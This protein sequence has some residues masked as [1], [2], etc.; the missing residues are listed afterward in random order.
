MGAGPWLSSF[1]LP[2]SLYRWREQRGRQG[3]ELAK[4][5]RLCFPGFAGRLVPG[6]ASGGPMSL[7]A[8]WLVLDA[9]RPARQAVFRGV[10]E[11]ASPCG[12]A[13]LAFLLLLPS[14]G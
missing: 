1:V 11:R 2:P 10:P 5:F 3:A 14:E 8:V 4:G 6:E 9:W 13:G 12:G 7:R